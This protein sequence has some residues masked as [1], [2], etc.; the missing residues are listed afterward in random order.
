M[1]K[2]IQVTE[3]EKLMDSVNE[4]VYQERLRQNEK[5]G[6]QRHPIGTWLSILGEEFGEVCQAAQS[7]LG[8]A[9]VKDTDA[10]NLYMECIHVAAVASAIAEQI[11]EQHSLKE[12][13]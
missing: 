4:E 6:I 3:N 5:W 9:S 10:D 8:L 7:E 11:K 1:R 13:A 12:V 2:V